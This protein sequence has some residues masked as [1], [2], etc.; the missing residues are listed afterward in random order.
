MSNAHSQ[1][2]RMYASAID[3][4]EEFLIKPVEV[5]PGR[6]DLSVFGTWVNQPAT[7]QR[8]IPVR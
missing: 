7:N 6:E 2:S 8:L 3:T 5:V 4:A 1:Y